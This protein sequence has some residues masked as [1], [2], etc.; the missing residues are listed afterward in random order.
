MNQNIYMTEEQFEII[1]LKTKKSR[2]NNNEFEIKAHHTVATLHILNI[3]CH[4]KLD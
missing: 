4:K 3:G 1:L 2:T